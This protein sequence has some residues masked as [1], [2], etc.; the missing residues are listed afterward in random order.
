MKPVHEPV[1]ERREQRGE[2][3]DEDEAREEGVDG[4]EDL[5]AVRVELAALP[6]LRAGA[7]RLTGVLERRENRNGVAA[8]PRVGRNERELMMQRLADQH[9]IEWIAVV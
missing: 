7:V 9:S 2:D 1:H 8:E 6:L 4:G 5:G 3:A